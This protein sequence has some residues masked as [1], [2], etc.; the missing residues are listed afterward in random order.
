[1]EFLSFFVDWQNIAFLPLNLMPHLFVQISRFSKSVSSAF[2]SFSF[3]MVLYNR[4]SSAN[5]RTDEVT[6]SGRSFIWHKN[7]IGQ[8]T[9][10]WGTPESTDVYCECSPST[11]VFS[12]LVV[13]KFVSHECRVSFMPYC[14]SLFRICP[15][16]NQLRTGKHYELSCLH[17]VY[18]TVSKEPQCARFSRVCT[19]SPIV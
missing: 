11:M 7:I 13:R 16:F 1:M 15:V 2:W 10:P 14:W 18:I 19:C 17:L 9:V 3:L 8:S 6:A 5:K 4:Q 12:F